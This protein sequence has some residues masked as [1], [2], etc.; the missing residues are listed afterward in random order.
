VI[1]Y[2]NKK[3]K[4][5]SNSENGELSNE[6]VFTYHQ[7]ENILSCSYKDTTIK[8]GELIGLVAKD[9]SIEMRYLQINSNNEIMSGKCHSI[10]EIMPNGKIRLHE[11]WQWT[12]GDLSK[13]TSILEE[14]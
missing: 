3:F 10:P 7:V 13:G 6:M 9:G 5:I 2:H 8:K 4:V 11:N 1:N 14:I 12:S